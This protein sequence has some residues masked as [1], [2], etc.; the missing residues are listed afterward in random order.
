MTTVFLLPCTQ[1]AFDPEEGRALG[2]AARTTLMIRNI[3][4]KYTQAMVLDILKEHCGYGP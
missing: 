3:P 2:D 1:Y 4:N